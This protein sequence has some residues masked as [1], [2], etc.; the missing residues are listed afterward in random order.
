MIPKIIHLCWLSED[1]YPPMIKK[2]IESW[3]RHLPDYEIWLWD[4]K[5]FD[6]NSV[7]WTEQAYECKKYAFAADYIRLYALYHYGGIYLDSDIFV[8]KSFDD[9]LNLP[10]FIGED[11]V[12]LFEPAVIGC[13]AGLPWIETVLNRY[14][15]RP[16]IM[17]DGSIDTCA[18]PIVFRQQLGGL[19][20]FTRISKKDDFLYDENTLNIFDDGFFNSRDYIGSIRYPD[21]YCSHC[22]LGS[23]LKTKSNIKLKLRHLLPRVVVNFLY[24]CRYK[25]SKIKSIQIPYQNKSSLKMKIFGKTK[26]LVI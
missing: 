12:H 7:L 20:T 1:E 8:Y 10:Y 9:L 21:S 26:P 24:F 25:C 3:K 19:Y 6:I 14:R 15:E 23:W 11:F 22:F 13:E 4:T 18:L 5:R 2:C 16:F 17:K